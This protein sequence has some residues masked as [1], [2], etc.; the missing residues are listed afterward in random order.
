MCR[1]EKVKFHVKFN[2]TIFNWYKLESLRLNERES[3]LVGL[4]P[5]IFT[6]RRRRDPSGSRG[7][8]D[9]ALRLSLTT[10]EPGAH[11]P[12]RGV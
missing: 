4:G 2:I 7:F 12:G 8:D 10:P 1:L 6:P 9:S 3:R 11:P 5:M